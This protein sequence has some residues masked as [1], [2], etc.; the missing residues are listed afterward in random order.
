M[1][2]RTAWVVLVALCVGLMPSAGAWSRKHTSVAEG[3]K[4]TPPEDALR[5]Y[6]AR[7]RAKQA[8]EIKTPG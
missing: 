2:L 5:A 7:V 3:T 1:A 8:A 4:A 6:I